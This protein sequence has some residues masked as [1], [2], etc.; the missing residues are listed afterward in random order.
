MV[1]IRVRL[2]LVSVMVVMPSGPCKCYVMQWEWGCQISRNLLVEYV[3]IQ[4]CACV[5]IYQ[6]QSQ[7]SMPHQ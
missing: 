5:Y 2:G 7:L 6:L 4:L 3:L 1:A